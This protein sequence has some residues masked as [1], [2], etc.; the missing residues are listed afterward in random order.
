MLKFFS[1][2]DVASHLRGLAEELGE[3]TNSVRIELNKLEEV[4]LLKKRPVGQKMVYR[5]N[6]ENPF[7]AELVALVS[8]YLGFDEI[9]RQIFSILGKVEAVYVQGDYARG[10]DSGTVDVIIVGAVEEDELL[11]VASSIE[12]KISRHIHI[13]WMHTNPEGLNIDPLF[14]LC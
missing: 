12:K 8:K 3:S 5:V 11:K 4:G 6:D 10:I 7:Y 1:R 9:S 13:T 14:Q 2:P